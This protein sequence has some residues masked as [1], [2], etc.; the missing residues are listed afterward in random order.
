MYSDHSHIYSYMWTRSHES[1]W[2]IGNFGGRLICRR[3]RIR[4]F[5]VA[6]PRGNSP[7]EAVVMET[8]PVVIMIFMIKMVMMEMGSLNP[9]WWWPFKAR[10]SIGWAR[11]VGWGPVVATVSMG[12]MRSVVPVGEICRKINDHVKWSSTFQNPVI[13]SYQVFHP[14]SMASLGMGR[15]KDDSSPDL[16][17]SPFPKLA[18]HG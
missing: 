13:I 9:R 3:H 7:M 1:C 16:Q 6:I 5:P 10:M 8:E 18:F 17:K 12:S 14:F 15:W 11:E 2:W 4:I